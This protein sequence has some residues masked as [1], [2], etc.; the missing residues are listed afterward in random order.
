MNDRDDNILNQFLPDMKDLNME[1]L[2]LYLMSEFVIL[3]DDV[4]R[5]TVTPTLS[6]SQVAMNLYQIIK[7]RRKLTQFLTAL[8]R[9]SEQN[10]GHG[11]LYEKISRDREQGIASVSSVKSK[12]HTLAQDIF[13]QPG[14]P[15]SR[16]SEYKVSN[17]E[18]TTDIETQVQ[19]THVGETD[20]QIS[21][22]TDLPA[23]TDLSTAPLT[24]ISMETN[25]CSPSNETAGTASEKDK[26]KSKF[27][28]GPI[29][30]RTQMHRDFFRGQGA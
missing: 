9:S 29:I 17:N 11:E 30:Y 14:E 26:C 5:L 1:D 6:K 12:V 23:P 13:T 22:N 28:N 4:I 3:D 2:N 16:S 10:P 15:E 7:S 24:D 18:P 25:Q 27:Y 19:D 20:P 21:N 8:K